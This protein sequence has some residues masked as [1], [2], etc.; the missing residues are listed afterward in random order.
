MP[1]RDIYLK[2][3]TIHDYS[4][5]APDDHSSAPITY[6]RDCMR[7]AG[8]EDGTIPP[9]EVE[10]RRLT[11]LVYREYLDP[12][13]LVPKPDKLV[14]ADINEPAFDHRV[15]GTV[16][17]ARP[18]ERLRIRVK[19]DDDAPHSFH[20]HGLKYGIDSD[21]AWPFGI[22]SGDGRRSDEICPGQT[23]TYTL[24]AQ[25]YMIGAWPFHDHYR[26]M[27]K[28]I[29]RGLFGGIVVLPGD[30]CDH[31]PRFPLGPALEKLLAGGLTREQLAGPKARFGHG[32]AEVPVALVPFL[33]V[34]EEAVRAPH[35]QPAIKPTDTLHV[36]MFIHVMRGKLEHEHAEGEGHEE[37]RGEEPGRER[38][39]EHDKESLP[40]LCFNGRTFVGNSPTIVA[41]A[42]QK[43]RWYVFNLDLGRGW[44]NFHPHG[45]HWPYANE[46]IDVRSLGPAESF[47]VETV[48]P[49]VLLL[50][51]EIEKYQG[52]GKRPAGAKPFKLRGDF[53]FHC[54][55]VADLTQGLAGL[56]RSTQTVW[57][58]PDDA[59]R[60]R[61]PL[62]P[63]HND[64]PGV[65][66]ER[67]ATAATG[68]VE[69]VPGLPGIIFMHAVL[70][71]NTARVLF[72]GEGPMPDQTRIWDQA[73]GLYTQPANQPADIFPDQ[74]LW[75]GSHA[76]LNDAAGTI[77]AFGG[78]GGVGADTERR[79]FLF[80]PPTLTFSPA[81]ELNIGRFYTTGV[82]L[83]D[84]RV[85]T[86]FG[87][88]DKNGGVTAASFEIFT[89][90][91]AGSWSAPEALPFDYLFYPWT[92]VLPGGDLFIAG[93][94]KPARRVNW[95]VTP[96]VDD[97]AGQFNQ[98]FS[99]RGI[100]MDG[101]AVLL[102]LRPPNY[103]PRVL[104]AG[105]V[106]A[107]TRQSAEWI[108]L[109]AA[110]PA[111]QALPNMN[112]GRDKV[113]SV[114][115]PD[116]QVVIVGGITGGPDG[117][118]VETFDPEDPAAGFRAGPTMQQERG[119]HSAALLLSDGSVLVGG[120]PNGATRPH[121]RY[122]PPYFFKARPAI[123]S[124]PTNI[125]YGAGFTV[126][127]TQ[128][129]DI[130]EV[131]LLRPGAVTHAFNM[132]QR[133]VGCA[134]V[135]AGGGAVQATAPPDGNVAPPGPYLLFV[136]NGDRVPSEGVWIRLG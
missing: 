28:S 97:P 44:H 88:D 104:I 30:E 63:G 130:A 13:F 4:P 55:S 118:P 19:N 5:V 31:L 128:A 56:V 23:W 64:C 100:N 107:D 27:G 95:T 80:D 2:I 74:N 86:L 76:Y 125:A 52:K 10:A 47:V 116:G 1:V 129:A 69:E 135:S 109:S 51:P 122:L 119:Y 67:C 24:D 40:S 14:L 15:P 36:P 59:A 41:A 127:T 115:L 111:W 43:I 66:F 79:A 136:V 12:N 87:T 29:N 112:A 114:L 65:D 54:Q 72:W 48:A 106:G 60:L 32:G 81:R 9:A 96:V 49:P 84:G 57:L 94:Q 124:A 70:L 22:G 120:D 83:G 42:G 82:T 18:G 98:V 121:E 50:P 108:D 92:F 75:S 39:E 134:I 105:G 17:Y 117:G 99:Q 71:P 77:L 33:A 45:Q 20:V 93:P 8:H 3:E 89:P 68:K 37:G 26:D 113:N 34:M 103:E 133:Y 61:L 123:N 132:A 16:I 53:L 73:T 131:V 21:G 25:N 58:K 11:A 91:G 78:F 38:A 90:G 62:D 35:L 85:M 126:N 110:A 102:P 7:N 101:T 46:S 6:K